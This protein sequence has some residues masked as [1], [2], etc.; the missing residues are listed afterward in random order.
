MLKALG[1][2]FSFGLDQ[3]ELAPDGAGGLRLARLG[4]SVQRAE[5]WR[6]THEERLL[7][8]RPHLLATAQV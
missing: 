7:D 1:E 8:G 2:G 5:G 4:G 3:V 6:L